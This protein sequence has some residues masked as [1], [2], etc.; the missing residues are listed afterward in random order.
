MVP[1]CIAL[2]EEIAQHGVAVHLPL[3]FGEPGDNFDA[4]RASKSIPHLATAG[5]SGDELIL[6]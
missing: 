3:L 1:Q 6:F 4:S 5:L 2:A